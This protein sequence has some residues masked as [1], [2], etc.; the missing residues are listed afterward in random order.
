MGLLF[1][2]LVFCLV[3]YHKCDIPTHCLTSQ[4][5][6]KWKFK[7]TA[8]KQ[9]NSLKSL[10]TLKCGITNHRVVDQILK[11]K[12]NPKSFT[13]SFDVDLKPDMT[14][15]MQ[16]KG[17]KFVGRWT[18]LYDEG[19]LM[20]FGEKNTPN[21]QSYFV[22]LKFDLNKRD[23]Y[24]SKCYESMIGWYHKG[25]KNWGCFKGHKDVNNYS[26]VTNFEVAN[27]MHVVE[28]GMKKASFLEFQ[29]IVDPNLP[30]FKEK[31]SISS[32]STEENKAFDCDINDDD[33]ISFLSMNSKVKNMNQKEMVKKINSMN[34]GWEAKEYEEFEGMNYEEIHEEMKN[35][36][37][38]FGENK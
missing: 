3:N 5:H 24:I 30:R 4:V 15:V 21:F 14:A 17:K 1:L 9:Y 6:G 23:F 37:I 7:A 32:S 27:K 10:Y 19:I 26:V 22:F 28:G 36:K 29:S 16:Q 8:L 11:Q 20:E 38:N 12:M 34:L 25:S 35:G 18:L 2:L 31:E 33:Q 13:N